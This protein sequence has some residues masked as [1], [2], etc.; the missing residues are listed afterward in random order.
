L[1]IYNQDFKEGQ[2]FL[3]ESWVFCRLKLE[4][5]FVQKWRTSSRGWLLPPTT[6]HF[7]RF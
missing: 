3:L 4:Y 1:I 6:F 2:T 7:S 5:V